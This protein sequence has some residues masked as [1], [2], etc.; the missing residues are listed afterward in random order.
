MFKTILVALD[1]SPQ[2]RKVLD[3]ASAFAYSNTKCNTHL[4]LVCV[5]DPAYALD[6]SQSLFANQEYPAAAHEQQHAESLIENALLQLQNR[7]IGCSA[8]TLTGDPAKAICAEAERIE[9]QL[10]VIGHRHLSFLGRLLDPSVGGKILDSSP[11][12]VLVEVR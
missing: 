11:C 1:G 4:H 10:I 7:G 12:P 9:S 2:S 5:L 8:K 6:D 3:L